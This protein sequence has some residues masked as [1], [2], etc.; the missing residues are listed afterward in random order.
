MNDVRR[1]ETPA[2]TY[3]DDLKVGVRFSEVLER[4]SRQELEVHERPVPAVLT[5]PLDFRPHP[6]D[7]TREVL[8]SDGLHAHPYPL[9]HR[10]E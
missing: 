9:G 3:F 7:E 1:V 2:E 10:V 8:P 5:H 6:F 4:Q